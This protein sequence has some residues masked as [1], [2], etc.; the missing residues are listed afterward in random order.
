ML[1]S[2]LKLTQSFTSNALKILNTLNPIHEHLEDSTSTILKSITNSTSLTSDKIDNVP[3]KNFIVSTS[4]QYSIIVSKKIMDL[5]DKIEHNFSSFKNE[6]LDKIKSL[7]DKIENDNHNLQFSQ[8]NSQP[9]KP[10][11]KKPENDDKSDKKKPKDYKKDYKKYKPPGKN[12]PDDEHSSIKIKIIKAAKMCENMDD[13]LRL[14]N[15]IVIFNSPI[16]FEFHIPE[17]HGI[18]DPLDQFIK[19]YKFPSP[20]S[21]ACPICNVDM[22]PYKMETDDIWSSHLLNDREFFMAIWVFVT[23]FFNMESPISILHGFQWTKVKVASEQ[24]NLIT[25]T[26]SM[27]AV[28]LIIVNSIQIIPSSWKTT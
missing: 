27:I 25:R 8:N 5:E 13:L 19:Q 20:T 23:N 24:S 1:D 7:A 12:E 15:E 14:L 10:D 2:E 17:I 21:C 4:E 6:L 18:D 28:Q 9:N 26:K 3:D 22:P 16:N 11:K